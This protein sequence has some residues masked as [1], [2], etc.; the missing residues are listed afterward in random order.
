MSSLASHTI[1]PTDTGFGRLTLTWGLVRG[2]AVAVDTIA[3]MADDAVAW[4]VGPSACATG[5][6][7]TVRIRSLARERR[8]GRSRGSG[9]RRRACSRPRARPSSPTSGAS[10]PACYASGRLVAGRPARAGRA[11]PEFRTDARRRRVRTFHEHGAARHRRR[12]HRPADPAVQRRRGRPRAGAARRRTSAAAR[13]AR[14]RVGRGG[15]RRRG[16]RAA[17]RPAGSTC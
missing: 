12:H 1:V 4:D 7:H 15:H 17:P 11:V 9:A 2:A 8:P 10:G 3:I 5:K 16:H 14:H 13:R 6:C